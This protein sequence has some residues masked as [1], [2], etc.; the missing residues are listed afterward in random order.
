ML[1]IAVGRIIPPTP[2]VVHMLTSRAYYS[3]MLHGKWELKLQVELRLLISCPWL[4]R[5]WIIQVSP[6]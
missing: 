3:V 5:A 1:I 4:G 2:K 6:I